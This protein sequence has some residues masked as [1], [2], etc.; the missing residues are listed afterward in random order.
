MGFSVR[1]PAARGSGQ[2]LANRAQFGDAVDEEFGTGKTSGGGRH[3]EDH[4][5]DALVP[6][7]R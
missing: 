6:G 3:A 7:G 5:F 4:A 1:H 2:I